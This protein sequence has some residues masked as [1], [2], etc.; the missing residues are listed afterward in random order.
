[1]HQSIHSLLCIPFVLITVSFIKLVVLTP[2][3]KTIWLRENIVIYS[4]LLVP[5]YS[6]C[7]YQNIYSGDAVL[8][9]CFLINP[10]RSPFPL[11]P[12]VFGC[13]AFVHVL[14]TSQ[15]KLSPWAHKCIFLGYPHTQKGYHCYNHE[16]RCSF[17]SA[18][19]TFFESTPFFS[20][21]S[22]GMSS[23]LIVRGLPLS[24]LGPLQDLW[25][26]TLI[27]P[28]RFISDLEIG[29]LYLMAPMLH[30][31]RLRFWLHL[32][33]FQRLMIYQLL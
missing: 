20:S 28:C 18:N 4:I 30:L 16:F 8:T 6:I 31:L 23:N 7:K 2:P 9:D 33:P 14:D 5:C 22:Q 29:M 17:V 15:D 12:R 11:T 25:L 1:M 27:L 10:I 26:P 13:V 3:N 21:P 19:F 32:F 24:S